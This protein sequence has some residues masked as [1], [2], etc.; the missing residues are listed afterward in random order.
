MGTAITLATKGVIGHRGT[1]TSGTISSG[2]MQIEAG[3]WQLLSIPV[4]F[5]YFNNGTGELIHDG[6]TVA[7]IKNYLLDQIEYNLGNS[8]EDY[9]EVANCYFGDEDAFRNYV[10]GTTNPASSQNFPLAYMD[11]T[12][13]EFTAFWI[14]SIHTSDI[15]IEWGEP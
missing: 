13:L 6:T 1:G 4:Q 9:I 5:G 15:V 14:K 7:R 2:E 10:P 8:A 3:V 12:R 11:G